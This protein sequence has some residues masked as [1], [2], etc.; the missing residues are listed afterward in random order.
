[1]VMRFWLIWMILSSVWL[2]V[3]FLLK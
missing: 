3:S 1:V 2:L